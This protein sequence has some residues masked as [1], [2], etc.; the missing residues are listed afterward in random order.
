M[1]WRSI[2]EFDNEFQERLNLIQSYDKNETAFR[3]AND[4]DPSSHILS[5]LDQLA[6]TNLDKYMQD[7]MPP[8]NYQGKWVSKQGHKTIKFMQYTM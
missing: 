8:M 1:N 4:L 6:Y 5:N 7:P 2:R 3:E